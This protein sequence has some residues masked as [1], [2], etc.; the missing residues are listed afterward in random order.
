[1]NINLN[2]SELNLNHFYFYTIFNQVG[3]GLGSGLV[4]GWHRVKKVVILYHIM[5]YFFLFPFT[6]A[7]YGI[8]GLIVVNASGCLPI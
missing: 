3:S 8:D 4:A 6:C 7:V 5:F 2:R 1:M